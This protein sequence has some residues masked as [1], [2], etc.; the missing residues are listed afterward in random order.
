MQTMTCGGDVQAGLQQYF[1]K[2]K[3]PGSVIQA[4]EI[5]GEVA[6]LA[7]TVAGLC[8]AFVLPFRHLRPDVH[9][10][11]DILLGKV[12]PENKNPQYCEVSKAFLGLL[13]PAPLFLSTGEDDWRKRAE[14]F[15]RRSEK[16]A[17]GEV[18]LGS[19]TDAEGCIS[20]NEVAKAEFRKD[21][22]RYLKKLAAALGRPAPGGQ[23]LVRWNPAGV[24]VSGEATLRV[25][26]EATYELFVE[27]DAGGFTCTGERSPSGVSIMWRFEGSAGG[28]QQFPHGNQ[29]PRWD[30]SAVDLAREIEREFAKFTGRR[31][32]R[33]A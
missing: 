20:Y 21:A 13:S 33:A 7:V 16:S 29:W 5:R 17:K 30:I 24:A 25:Q 12:Q 31:D 26:M 19:Y 10:G 4:C 3:K 1:E 28:H 2:R 18:L 9:F 14:A 15:V 23:K 11:Q 27:V 6:Y 32:M 8:R 22:T